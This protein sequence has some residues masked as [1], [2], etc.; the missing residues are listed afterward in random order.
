MHY[1]LSSNHICESKNMKSCQI[2]KKK[3]Q[4]KN[5]QTKEKT[6]QSVSKEHEIYI[7]KNKKIKSAHPPHSFSKSG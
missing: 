5:K 1:S 3:N 2:I 7:V 4:K 6:K